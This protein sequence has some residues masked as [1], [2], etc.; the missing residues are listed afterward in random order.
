M[1]LSGLEINIFIFECKFSR[2]ENKEGQLNGHQSR[3]PERPRYNLLKSI[4]VL[5][6][7]PQIAPTA[8]SEVCRFPAPPLG[9]GLRQTAPP[10]R[11]PSATFQPR[12]QPRNSA[13]AAAAR[14]ALQSRLRDLLVLIA[15]SLPAL[16][17][18]RIPLF[19]PGFLSYSTPAIL[20]RV[21]NCYRVR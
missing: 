20:V 1:Y 21:K 3:R 13:R 19:R 8:R 5:R 9:G 17:R 2:S 14:T 11:R 7:D 10:S 4:L 6:F 16:P 15:P 18:P 12:R